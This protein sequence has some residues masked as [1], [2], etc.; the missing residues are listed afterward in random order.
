MAVN[1]E[2]E[3]TGKEVVV[4]Y[5]KAAQLFHSSDTAETRM[6]RCTL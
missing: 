5:F 2:L 6:G 3:G 4:A 1:D